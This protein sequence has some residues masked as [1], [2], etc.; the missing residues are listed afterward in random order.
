VHQIQ[1]KVVKAGSAGT[2]G[3]AKGIFSVVDAA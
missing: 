2:I 1:I 3:G